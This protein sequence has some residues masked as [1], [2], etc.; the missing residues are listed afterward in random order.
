MIP[1]IDTSGRDEG[2]RPYSLY[3]K[4][5]VPEA[6]ESGGAFHT[7]FAHTPRGGPVPSPGSPG[8]QVS[9]ALPASCMALSF[10]V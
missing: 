2:E 7:I 4:G 6:E 1:I 10:F 8:Q 9:L 5:W 3:A